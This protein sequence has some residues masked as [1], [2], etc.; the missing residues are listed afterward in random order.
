VSPVRKITLRRI[1]DRKEAEEILNRIAKEQGDLYEQYRAL[2]SLW[3]TN[4]AAV[5]ELRPMFRIPEVDPDGQLSV[6]S[7]FVAAV[8][9][10]AKEIL[11][12]FGSNA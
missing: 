7:D 4:N 8:R 2:Y 3:R 10:V 1:R 12:L 9:S 6:T 11:P 5:T